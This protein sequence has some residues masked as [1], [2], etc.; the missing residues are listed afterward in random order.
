MR[1]YLI[2]HLRRHVYEETLYEPT[3]GWNSEHIDYKFTIIQKFKGTD[4][5]YQMVFL[6][7][8][9]RNSEEE[10]DEYDQA[11]EL[12]SG[13]LYVIKIFRIDDKDELSNFEIESEWVGA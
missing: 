3:S 9:E 11:D 13:E 4:D 10:E 5:N 1:E 2:N 8:L 6:G 12:R 7:Q